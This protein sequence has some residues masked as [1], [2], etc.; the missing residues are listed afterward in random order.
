MKE[1]KGNFYSL[2]E[3]VNHLKGFLQYLRKKWWMLALAGFFGALLGTVYY[4]RQKPKY[5]AVTTFILEEKSGGGGIAGLASQ[6]GFNVGSLGGGG[7]I[8]SGDNI[9]DILKSKKIVQQV[10]LSPIDNAGPDKATLADIYLE[11]TGSKKSWHKNPLLANISFANV[12]KQMSPIQDS[13]LNAIYK[14]IIK[15]H[16]ITDRPHKQSSIIKVKVTAGNSVF[17]RLMS[18][19]LVQEASKLYLDI[20]VGSIHDNIEQMQMRSDSLL[21]LLNAQSY[22]AAASQPLD[23]NPGMR[24]ATVHS[25]IANRDKTVLAALYTEVTKNLEMSKLLL[26]QQTPVIQF[27]D[28]PELLLNDSKKSLFWFVLLCSIGVSLIY[29]IGAS[30]VFMLSGNKNPSGLKTM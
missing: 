22:N 10:L 8:F 17:A 16:L 4:F 11:F 30:L 19:R 3:L 2:R 21:I 7:S 29:I 13:V 24:T 5:E 18:E 6:F 28:T 15:D 1:D 14:G 26:S 23:F 25:E 9:L 20:R 12:R 27:L